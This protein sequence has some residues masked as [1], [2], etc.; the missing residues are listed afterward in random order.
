MFRSIGVAALADAQPRG[1]KDAGEQPRRHAEAAGDVLQ[2]LALG[3][4]LG[5][6]AG[7]QH[8]RRQELRVVARGAGL[9]V[10]AGVEEGDVVAALQRRH[11]AVRADLVGVAERTDEV[12][13]LGRL[14]RRRSPPAPRD[15]TSRAPPPR[16]GGWSRGR[17]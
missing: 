12:D 10:A 7:D 8:R 5:A 15:S 17:C 4:D 2:L 14:A 13:R 11:L 3:D 1:A 16:R 9:G 6:V